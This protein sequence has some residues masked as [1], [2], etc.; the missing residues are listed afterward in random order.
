MGQLITEDHCPMTDWFP[1]L[2][3]LIP[4][5]LAPLIVTFWLAG[6]NV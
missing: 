5:T 1:E 6:V 2:L 4:E 3:K